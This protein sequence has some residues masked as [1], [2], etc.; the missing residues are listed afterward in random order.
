MEHYRKLGRFRRDHPSVGAG[1]HTMVSQNP[2]LFSREYSKGDYSDRVLVGLE[3]APG[4]KRLPAGKTF[5]DGT[6]LYDYYSG[7]YATVRHGYVTI[8]SEEATVLLGQ[9]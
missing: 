7:T 3:L 4:K 9:K 6:E 8:D 1:T 5:E 2:Y